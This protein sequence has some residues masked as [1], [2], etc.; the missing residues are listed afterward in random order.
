MTPNWRNTADVTAS[1][2]VR[3]PVCDC[4]IDRPAAVLPTFTIT[5]GLLQL[6]GVVGREH[7]RAAV[8]EALDVTGDHADLGLVGEVAGEVG[9]LEVDLVARRRPVREAD[10]ELLALEHR[11]ALVARLRD[12]RDRRAFEVVA[13]VLERV[14]VRVRAEQAHVAAL[15]RASSRRRSRFLPSA[16]VSEKPAAKI[17]A[18]FALRC[19]TSSNVS[20]AR[21][22]RMIARSMSPGTSNTDL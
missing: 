12:Q 8:L 10:A 2:P 6:R 13:E 5:I 20:S 22:V 7:Q 1:E 4:A 21:P 9:E 17:T 18:N 19:S 16:P 3:W 14:E 11:P 15:A